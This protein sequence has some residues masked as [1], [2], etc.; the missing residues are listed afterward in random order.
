MAIDHLIV[1]F[2]A[3][4]CWRDSSPYSFCPFY[5]LNPSD[6]VLT[7]GQS[8]GWSLLHYLGLSKSC[9]IS[10]LS[11][12]ATALSVFASKLYL[13]PSFNS[14]STVELALHYSLYKKY[15]FQLIDS[16]SLSFHNLWRQCSSCHR[17]PISLNSEWTATL[18][19]YY[20]LVF[21]P[22]AD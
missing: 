20:A 1:D 6:A 13:S 2:V 21:E 7:A 3:F 10:L 15:L 11:F 12:T 16:V 4:A 22:F 5:P 8:R 18:W 14:A 19:Y 17:Y 9:L